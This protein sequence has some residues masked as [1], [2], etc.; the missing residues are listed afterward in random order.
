MAKSEENTVG[1]M[2]SR[3][4]EGAG[5]NTDSIAKPIARKKGNT[6][7]QHHGESKESRYSRDN[8]FV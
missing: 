4:A 5:Y 3:L 1:A 2:E 7:K 6:R 8:Y